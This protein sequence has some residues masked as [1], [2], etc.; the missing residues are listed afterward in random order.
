MTWTYSGD[1]ADNDL[2]ELR[3]KIG[4]TDPSDPELQDEELQ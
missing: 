4:D 3:F 1:P 2:D